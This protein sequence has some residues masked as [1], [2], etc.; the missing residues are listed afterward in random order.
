MIIRTKTWSNYWVLGQKWTQDKYTF[1][2]N[3]ICYVNATKINNPTG[4]LQNYNTQLLLLNT[5]RDR[6]VK[7]ALSKTVESNVSSERTIQLDVLFVKLVCC[8]KNA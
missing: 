3:C 8:H 2:W 4:C 7:S 5:G 6:A 1:M